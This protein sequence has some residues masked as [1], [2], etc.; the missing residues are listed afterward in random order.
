MKIAD[1]YAD[2]CQKF[3][4]SLSGEMVLNPWGEA[5]SKAVAMHNAP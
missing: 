5:P 3:P 4:V 1:R 2:A